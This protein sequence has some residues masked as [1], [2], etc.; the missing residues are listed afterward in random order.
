MYS[1]FNPMNGQEHKI[2]YFH[3]FCPA[4]RSICAKKAQDAA[5]I[6]AIKKISFF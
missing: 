2:Y 3:C 6:A 1:F 4:F 5:A